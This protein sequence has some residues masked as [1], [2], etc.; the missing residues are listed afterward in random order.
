MLFCT[1]LENK[2]INIY[3][4]KKCLGQKQY[5]KQDSF[6]VQFP[7]PCKTKGMRAV[8]RNSMLQC[9]NVILLQQVLTLIKSQGGMWR[10]RLQGRTLKFSMWRRGPD[11]NSVYNV[12]YFK[13]Y[14]T[15][16]RRKYNCNLTLCNCIYTHKYNYI[17]H[18][19]F[20]F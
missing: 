5:R 3:C 15:K 7:F 18:Y 2:L 6:Y 13:N 16:S 10:T 1:H 8:S 19:S 14:V 12:F 17:I 11:P 20:N 4:F 9:A